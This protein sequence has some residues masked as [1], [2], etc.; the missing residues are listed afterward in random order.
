MSNQAYLN[1]WF[2]EFPEELILE[3]FGT[4]L[5]TVPFSA[6]KPGFTHFVIRALD[7]RET[8][9]LEQ[10][11]R[12]VPLDAAGIIEM[13]KDHLNSDCAYEVRALST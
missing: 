10:D 4:F 7:F 11:M 8:P 6:T 5:S 12:S 2:Q 9:I 1:I 3:R 13:A